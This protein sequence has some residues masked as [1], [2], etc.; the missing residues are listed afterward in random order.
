M[1]GKVYDVTTYLD[2][3][4]GQNDFPIWS[5]FSCVH[6]NFT[7]GVVCTCGLDVMLDVTGSDVRIS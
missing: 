1:Y 6:T 5:L 3:H 2:E 4:P 7:Y